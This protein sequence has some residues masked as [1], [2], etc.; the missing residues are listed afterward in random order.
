MRE[1]RTEMAVLNRRT[2]RGRHFFRAVAI[3]T[4][5]AVAVGV[6]ASIAEAKPSTGCRDA[7][8][9]L[10]FVSQRIGNARAAGDTAEVMFWQSEYAPAGTYAVSVCG[11]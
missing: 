4:F 5:A 11:W 3:A 10:N 8:A 1:E 6:P 7:V 2:N 9:Y